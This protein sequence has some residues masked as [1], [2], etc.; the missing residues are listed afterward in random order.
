VGAGL[1][2]ACGDDGDTGSGAA[3]SSGAG[4]GGASIN[5]CDPATAV[6]QTG[7]GEAT[8]SVT[9]FAYSPKCFKVS[10]GTK[11]TFNADF[12]LH[13]LVGG[14]IE[15]GV[16]EPYASSPIAHTTTGMTASFTLANAGSF[17]FYCDVHGPAGMTGAVYVQP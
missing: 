4:G 15:S 7:K 9:G 12:A 1:V 5:G 14:V 10:A 11:V 13:P 6:D 17:G 16:K 2:A 3:A 8:V